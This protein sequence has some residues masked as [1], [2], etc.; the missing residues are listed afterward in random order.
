[1]AVENRE[2]AHFDR[3]D[4]G[5]DGLWHGGLFMRATC[6]TGWRMVFGVISFILALQENLKVGGGSGIQGTARLFCLDERDAMKATLSVQI[7]DCV[8]IQT[9]RTAPGVA[10]GGREVYRKRIRAYAPAGGG[11]LEQIMSVMPRSS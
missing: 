11:R 2:G 6:G 8:N 5:Q 3:F 1:M 9:L 4:S 10:E 7:L